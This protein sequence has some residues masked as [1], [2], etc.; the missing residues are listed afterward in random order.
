MNKNV[1]EIPFELCGLH[2][3]EAAEGEEQSREVEGRAV[4]YG[5][6]SNNLTPWS[7][8]REVY[9]IM[10]PGSITQSII[11][12]S[13]IFFTAYHDDSIIL[14]RSEMGKGT[15]KLIVDGEG[16]LVRCALPNTKD[17]DTI[18]ELIRRGDLHA[19]S[20]AYTANE[21]D[22]EN[23]VS[24]EM[25]SERSADGKEVWLRHVK[26]VDELFDVTVARRPA[27]SQTSIGQREQNPEDK[28]IDDSIDAMKREQEAA[29]AEQRKQ[30]RERQISQMGRDIDILEN[31]IFNQ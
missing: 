28:H 26:K 13:D 11:D 19:M 23:A 18:L 25:L 22:S 27:Y 2:V 29:A 31:E 6:R 15:L 4:V 16:V 30:Q 21:E 5:K 8:L 10:Q 12:K 24:Y 3:R 9:E 14:G 1:R 20:F 17:G 7:S